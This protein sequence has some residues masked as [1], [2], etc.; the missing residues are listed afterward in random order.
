MTGVPKISVFHDGRDRVGES[1]LW[2][3]ATGALW[4]VDI[5]S[6]AFKR[7]PARQLAAAG[8]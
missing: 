5:E 6:K 3:A 2:D 7:T 8:L 1:P 4:W